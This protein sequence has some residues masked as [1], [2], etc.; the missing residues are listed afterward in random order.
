[1][2]ASWDT[3]PESWEET[4]LSRWAAMPPGGRGWCARLLRLREEEED[5]EVGEWGWDSL[6]PPPPPPLPKPMLAPPPE[7]RE[8]LLW[9]LLTLLWGQVKRKETAQEEDGRE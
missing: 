4:L 1:M 3:K 6:P 5:D 7:E 8:V 2:F 9:V